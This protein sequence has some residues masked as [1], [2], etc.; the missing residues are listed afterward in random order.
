MIDVISKLIPE[1]VIN[2]KTLWAEDTHLPEY[3]YY[4]R[5]IDPY[6][7]EVIDVCYPSMREIVENVY[8][9]VPAD[10]LTE[11]YL[12]KKNRKTKTENI[13][14]LK[15]NGLSHDEFDWHPHESF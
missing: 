4:H 1:T 3:E 2:L 5:V 8:Y 7:R 6:K 12:V 14:K 13:L 11:H 15:C 9:N 10:A